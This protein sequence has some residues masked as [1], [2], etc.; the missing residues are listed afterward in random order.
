M[1]HTHRSCPRHG[2][3]HSCSRAVTRNSGRVCRRLQKRR[4]VFG[5]LKNAGA[6]NGRSQSGGLVLSGQGLDPPDLGHEPEI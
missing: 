6:S 1:V 5:A 4:G 2:P 3:L